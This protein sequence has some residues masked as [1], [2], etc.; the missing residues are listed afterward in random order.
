[1]G[2]DDLCSDDDYLNPS[3]DDFP[4]E[5]Q[6]VE[7]AGEVEQIGGKRKREDDDSIHEVTTR[8]TSMNLLINAGRDLEKQ[9]ADVQA[10]FLWTGLKHY[11]QLKGESISSD[12]KI[13]DF[14]LRTSNA[15]S[16]LNRLKDVISIKKL[17]KWKPIGSP[18]VIILCISARRSVAVLK[19]LS[20]LKIRAAK[21][22]AKH[23]SVD[24]QKDMLKDQSFGMAVGTPNRVRVLC[25]D[26]GRGK[27]PLYLGKTTHI[28]IDCHVNQKGYTVCTLPDTAPDT[29]DFLKQKVIPQ[30][31]KRRDIKISFL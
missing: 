29:M 2:G 25:N 3:V 9:K 11:V 22:F 31:K 1:M 26:E 24:Q 27:A 23:M 20:A 28:I 21:L 4:E 6:I 8:K 7:V 10:K 12:M 15:E 30:V 19:E 16:L 17:K 14:H 18:M 5:N 13:E